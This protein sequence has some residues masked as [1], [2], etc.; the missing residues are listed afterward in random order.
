MDKNVGSVDKVVRI[1]GG[2]AILSLVF[3]LEGS[4]RWLGLIGIGPILTV[5]FSWCPAYT[6][7]GISTIKKN[8]S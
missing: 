4:A 8:P 7:F 5:V 1:V 6:V 3:L 2:L